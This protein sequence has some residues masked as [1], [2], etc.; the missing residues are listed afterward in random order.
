MGLE[1][2][3]F[4]TEIQ[5]YVYGNNRVFSHLYLRSHKYLFGAPD[6]LGTGMVCDGLRTRCGFFVIYWRWACEW[7]LSELIL[8][9][10]S[11]YS[12]V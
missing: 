5:L 7:N 11:K 9:F 4:G 6:S 10:W 12:A 2:A 8:H 3:A 1:F